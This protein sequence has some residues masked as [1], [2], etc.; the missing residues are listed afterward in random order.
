MDIIKNFILKIKT[1]ILYRFFDQTGKFTS[2]LIRVY[3]N[4]FKH[5]RFKNLS[6]LEIGVDNGGSLLFW[7]DYFKHPGTKITGIDIALPAIRFPRR[8]T[9]KKCDQND[10]K[11]LTDI[12][13]EFGPF[14]IILDDGSHFTRETKNCFEQLFKHVKPEGLY[15]I[16]DWSIGYIGKKQFKGM[17]E[18]VSDIV[19]HAPELGIDRFKVIWNIGAT[20]IFRKK[21]TKEQKVPE[22]IKK[23]K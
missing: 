21:G 17:V 22:F 1:R 15:I 11:A 10:S 12:A 2:G 9:V 13:R 18:L 7:S 14:D 5:L 16:E 8:V 4:E 20:A 6:I 3:K 19:N 23:M